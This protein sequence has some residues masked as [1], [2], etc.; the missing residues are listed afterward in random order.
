MYGEKDTWYGF[1]KKYFIPA[2][3]VCWVIVLGSFYYPKF[4][5]V[6]GCILVSTI[7]I[8]LVALMLSM[9]FDLD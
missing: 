7:L 1:K 9:F 4:G 3:I 8:T 6:M 2:N 5:F